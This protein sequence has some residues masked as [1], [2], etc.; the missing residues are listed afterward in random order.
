MA[1]KIFDA[2]NSCKKRLADAGIEDCY[3]DAKQ[4]IKRVTGY[5]NMEILNHYNDELTEYQQKSFD[6]MIDKRCMRYP[7]QYILGDWDFYGRTF[8]VGAGVLIPRADSETIIDTAKEI[9]EGKK[10]ENILDLCAGSGCLGITLSL[11]LGGK[12]VCLEKYEP[13]AK[14]LR[15]NAK[16][17]NPECEIVEGDIFEGTANDKKYD[18]IVSNPPYIKANDME[19]LQPEVTFEPANA[20]YGGEDGL[21][22]YRAIAVNYAG[23]LKNG[24]VLMFEAGIDEANDIAEILSS[25]GF[26]DVQIRKDAAGVDRVVFGTLN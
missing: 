13:A 23:A 25:A 11:E 2:Y 7:L 21:M 18:L 26:G 10:C 20:L 17:L 14:F 1:R 6:D 8:K 19:T 3:F 15:E 22:F 12:A 5:T 16:I 4:M 24:G 9:F